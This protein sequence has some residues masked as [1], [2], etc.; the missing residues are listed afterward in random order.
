MR[1]RERPKTIVIADR[2]EELYF[3]AYQQSAKNVRQGTKDPRAERECQNK[4]R[5]SGTLSRRPSE[6]R[7]NVWHT[8]RKRDL[9]AICDEHR[10]NVWYRL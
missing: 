6:G 5:V 7:R 3:S 4:Y 9:K 8:H 10:Q 2:I 1:L